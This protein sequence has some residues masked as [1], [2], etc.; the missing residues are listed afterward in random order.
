MIGD[1]AFCRVEMGL[2]ALVFMKDSVK[3]LYLLGKVNLV[4]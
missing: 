2:A 4:E 1:G 3:R